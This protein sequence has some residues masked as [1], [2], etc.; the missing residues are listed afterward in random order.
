MEM[1]HGGARQTVFSVPELFG[2]FRLAGELLN[3][4]GIGRAKRGRAHNNSTHLDLE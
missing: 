2:T 3:L 1:H 4:T